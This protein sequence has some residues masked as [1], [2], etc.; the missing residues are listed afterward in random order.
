M[1]ILLAED[2]IDA[3]SVL[4]KGL[5]EEGYAVDIAVSAAEA[6]SRVFVNRYDL[7]LLDV[8]L[9]DRDG[10]SVCRDL[11]AT[12]IDTPIFML[13]ARD[14][15]QDRIRGLNL[16]ADDYLI[17]PY[18]YRELLA[19]IRRLVRRQSERPAEVIV[20]ADLQIHTA[21]H[22]VERAGSPIT[23]T[24]REYALLEYLARRVGHPV[25]REEI[26]RNVWDESDKAYSNL[27]ETYL[28]RLRRKIDDGHEVTLLHTRRGEGYVLSPEP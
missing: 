19:R 27:I 28:G 7:I 3:A 4:A 15:V 1:R 8:M 12:G 9:P 23:L 16:G 11:R 5:R 10:Y 6:D 17:K 14:A 2:Q 13:T 22:H 24:A 20:I 18:E 21:T 25:R 26:A